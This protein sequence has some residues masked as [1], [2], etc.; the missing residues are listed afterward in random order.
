MRV[1]NEDHDRLRRCG[2][3]HESCD[4]CKQTR[5]GQ[6]RVGRPVARRRARLGDEHG[7]VSRQW[8]ETVQMAVALLSR[9]NRSD[10]LRERS[11]RQ[12]LIIFR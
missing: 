11:V 1:V 2:D 3:R 10:E 9:E 7:K 5:A 12:D 6:P 4:P 8:A